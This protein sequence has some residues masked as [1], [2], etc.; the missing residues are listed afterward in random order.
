MISISFCSNSVCRFDQTS[1]FRSLAKLASP[2]SLRLNAGFLDLLNSFCLGQRS[3]KTAR[4]IGTE[5]NSVLIQIGR[6]NHLHYVIAG[7]LEQFAEES[8][9]SMLIWPLSG[10][11]IHAFRSTRL[12]SIGCRS[13]WSP[14]DRRYQLD[15]Q[16][17]EKQSNGLTRRSDS[18]I[19]FNWP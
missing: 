8:P 15:E 5:V 11:W 14:P 2:G 18:E 12:P 16:S 17:D 1:L 13:D 4:S 3:D 7:F 6:Q 19:N 9:V 10:G